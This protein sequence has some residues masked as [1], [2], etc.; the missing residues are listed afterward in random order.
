MV[1]AFTVA[2]SIT[3]ALAIFGVFTLPG[4]FV[5]PIIVL[6]IAV[7]AA[8]NIRNQKAEN[9]WIVALVVCGRTRLEGAKI[10][11]LAAHLLRILS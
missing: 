4:W 9:R 11:R 8:E 3:L 6:S 2:H 7:A 1:T 5:E 10:L